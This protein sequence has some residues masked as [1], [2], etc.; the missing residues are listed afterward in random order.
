MK[1]KNTLPLLFTVLI[2]ACYLDE[3]DIGPNTDYYSSSAAPIHS[4][5]SQEIVLL[6]TLRDPNLEYSYKVV[7]MGSQTWIT[8]NLNEIP[9]SGDWWCYGGKDFHENCRVYGKLY[10][11]AAAKTVCPE[12]WKLPSKEDYEILSEWDSGHLTATSVWHAV[13]GGEKYEDESR[14]YGRLDIDGNWWSS[15]DVGDWAYYFRLEKGGERLN[16][17]S[18]KKT[19]GFS[20]RCIKK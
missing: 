16:K 20:V 14:Y 18:Q 15:S 4:S 1:A 12:G 6:D 19:Y 8:Q 11:W 9:K 10:N 13:F 17:Y 5:S 3:K 2:F 7:K